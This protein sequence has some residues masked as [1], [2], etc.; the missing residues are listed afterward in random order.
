MVMCGRARFLGKNL[1]R[2]NMTKN[3]PKWSKN[4]VFGFF[5][6][7]TSSVLSDKCVK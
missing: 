7:I 4:M 1:Y 5:K 6:K 3:G 2:A